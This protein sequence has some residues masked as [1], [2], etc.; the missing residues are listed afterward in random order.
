M[1]ENKKLQPENELI[2]LRQTDPR[3]K[4]EGDL[5]DFIFFDETEKNSER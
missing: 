4:I 3:F 5:D 2:K 1:E